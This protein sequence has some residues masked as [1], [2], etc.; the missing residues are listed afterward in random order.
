[1]PDA[2]NAKMYLPILGLQMVYANQICDVCAHFNE[3]SMNAYMKRILCCGTNLI[4]TLN[5]LRWM[6]HGLM[7]E[8][9][10]ILKVYLYL[11]SQ[12]GFLLQRLLELCILM[13]RIF[14]LLAEPHGGKGGSKTVTWIRD[15]Q[16]LQ[17]QVRAFLMKP[18]KYEELLIFICLL[19]IIHISEKKIHN[20]SFKWDQYFSAQ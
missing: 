9:E 7:E 4:H 18:V 11:Q 16:I 6:H 1:M 3:P 13:W 17:S 2:G 15:Q 14:T 8:T 20:F 12:S 10:S 19:M 5:V